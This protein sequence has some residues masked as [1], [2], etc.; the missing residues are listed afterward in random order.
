[1]ALMKLEGE[2]VITASTVLATMN[3]GGGAD[4]I[5]IPAGRYFLNTIGSGGATRT[6]LNEIAFQMESS[7]GAGSSSV[8]VDDT[9]DTALGKVTISRSSGFSITW[10]STSLRNALG[11]TGNSSTATSHTGSNH[12]KYLFMP[13]CGRSGVMGPETSDGAIE[14]DYTLSMGTDGTVYALA[15]SKRYMDSLE[16]RTLKGSKT[17][18]ALDVTTNEA[19]E[20]FYGDVISLGLRVRF[21]KDRSDD[22]TFRTWV[23]EDGS[24]FQPSPVKDDWV[25]STE[26]LWAIRYVVRK[27]T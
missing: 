11:F 7:M 21:H 13:N 18:S 4:T 23:I 24:K 16:F 25:D 9:A 15:Y 2:I 6:F 19:L 20:Q 1:M 26:S 10:S 14:A 27:T 17:W 3:D 12:A 5:T 8:T 22:A